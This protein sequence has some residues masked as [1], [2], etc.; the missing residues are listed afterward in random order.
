[1]NKLIGNSKRCQYK[2]LLL[3]HC[4]I[5]SMAACCGYEGS[6]NE[7]IKMFNPMVHAGFIQNMWHVPA[8]CFV[9]VYN[10]LCFLQCLYLPAQLHLAVEECLFG[11]FR[12][13]GLTN[14]SY[15]DGAHEVRHY[16]RKHSDLGCIV[17]EVAKVYV[18]TVQANNY[19][20][21]C[22]QWH[23]EKAIFEWRKPMIPHNEDAIQV[24][25]HFAN[26]FISQARKSPNRPPADKVLDNLIYNYSPTFTGKK[27]KSFEEV[28]IFS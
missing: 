10:E 22:T 5:N 8:I 2:K 28:Y 4:S 26:H 17:L 11:S 13:T 25:Q 6:V 9:A 24:T 18:S 14:N 7:A 15:F 16:L 23:P 1:M 3:K 19:P 21:T 20:I 27:S 12:I